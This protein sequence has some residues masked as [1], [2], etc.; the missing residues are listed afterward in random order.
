M[1]IPGTQ[2]KARIAQF[3]ETEDPQY[4]II[5]FGLSMQ[6]VVSIVLL[7]WFFLFTRESKRCSCLVI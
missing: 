6:M 1:R 5:D 7:W 3:V 2:L 4:D